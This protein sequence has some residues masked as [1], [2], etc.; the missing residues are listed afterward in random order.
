MMEKELV[1]RVDEVVLVGG[2]RADEVVLVG[3][4]RSAVASR[5]MR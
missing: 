3:G 4:Q 2:R 1:V 5:W